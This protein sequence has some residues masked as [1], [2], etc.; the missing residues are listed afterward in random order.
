MHFPLSAALTALALI[1]SS[2]TALPTK[3]TQPYTPAT[4]L[5][6]L[7]KL[8]PKSTLPAP[9]GL[10]LKYVVLGIGTQ[11]YTCLTGDSNAAPGTTGAVG[12]PPPPPPR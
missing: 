6:A 4:N 9:D 5:D 1:A 11:N 2:I 8:F 12:K 10:K 7:A 3:Q